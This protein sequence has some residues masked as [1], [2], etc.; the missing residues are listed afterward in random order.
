MLRLC[1]DIL[2]FRVSVTSKYGRSLSKTWHPTPR[3][4]EDER[5]LIANKLSVETL[6]AA[7]PLRHAPPRFLP[8]VGFASSPVIL[9]QPPVACSS[10]VLNQVCILFRASIFDVKWLFVSDL[11]PVLDRWGIG[12][13]VG[14]LT[15]MCVLYDADTVTSCLV[16]ILL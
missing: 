1:Y 15:C 10:D 13:R 2:K 5:R 8:A 14:E 3:R 6:L 4:P 16:C 12:L 9:Y 7:W 11:Q